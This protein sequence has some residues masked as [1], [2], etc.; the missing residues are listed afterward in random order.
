[1]SEF[2]N[3]RVTSHAM[4]RYRERFDANAKVPD[5]VNAALEGR[6]LTRAEKRKLADQQPDLFRANLRLGAL[7]VI[8]RDVINPDSGQLWLTNVVHLQ[9]A[10]YGS[11]QKPKPRLKGTKPRPKMRRPFEPRRLG[12]V[13]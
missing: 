4:D 11:D 10:L 6:T 8:R 13:G 2:H 12:E 5:L 3:L 9:G 7:F 1:M